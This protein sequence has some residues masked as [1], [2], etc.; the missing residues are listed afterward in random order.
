M[1]GHER[2]S[3]SNWRVE[4][5]VDLDNDGFFKGKDGARAGLREIRYMIHIRTD[6]DEEKFREF[7]YFVKSRCPVNDSL[8]GNI[9]IAPKG[10][11]ITR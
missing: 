4:R 10:I 6:V 5:K 2:S 7:V 1:Q 11:V 9:P 3:F 8:L